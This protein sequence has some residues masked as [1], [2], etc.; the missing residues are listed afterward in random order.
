MQKVTTCLMFVNEQHGKAEEAMNLYV[1]LFKNSC[2]VTIDRY[3]PDDGVMAGS[4]KLATFSIDGQELMA[5]DGGT[6]HNFTF[7]P[8]TSIMVR[9][10][11]EAEID[12]LYARLSDGGGVLMDLAKYP[13][14]EK[15]AWVADRFGVSWQLNLVSA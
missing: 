4:V 10:D 13:F 8:A 6:V 1:S 2:V 15:F 14:S 3:G 9:C 11:S 12:D 5:Q 7:T